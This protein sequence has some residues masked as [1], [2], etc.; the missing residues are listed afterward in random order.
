[1]ARMTTGTIDELMTLLCCALHGGG[2]PAVSDLSSLLSEARKQAVDS[3]LLALPSLPVAEAERPMLLEWLSEAATCEQRSRWMDRQVAKLAQL[4]DEGGVRYAVMKGQTCAHFYPRPLLRRTG[5]IDVYVPAA[6]YEHARTLLSGT[7]LQLKELTM[8]H[9][10]YVKGTLVVEL[11]FEVNKLQWPASDRRLRALTTVDFDACGQPDRFLPIGGRAVRT[12]PAE[13][14][15]VL[16]TAHSLHHVI[17]GGLG[18]RQ[19]AD[20][21]LVLTG[22][23]AELD[24]PRLLR[25]LRE[26]HL[27]R[28]F[29]VLAYVNVTHLGM[30][31]ELFAKHGLC[32]DDRRT[33]CLSSRLISWMSVC[34]NFG[35]EIDL[36]KG[37]WRKVRYYGLFFRNL[38]RFFRLCPTEMLA[39]PIMKLWRG[40]TG[41][42]HQKPRST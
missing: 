37:R 2:V 42:A 3:L 5:D 41:R 4:L 6:D 35:K 19:V 12:L 11:H 13:L 34:G 7:G 36:G 32:I 33:R 24:F 39:W 22:T 16:L 38:V 10:T 27:L 9:D 21:Q 8:L 15:M 40:L 20:W 26:L 17:S 28:M 25:L 18:L 29:R 31:K 1:M 14:N 23:A 30:S